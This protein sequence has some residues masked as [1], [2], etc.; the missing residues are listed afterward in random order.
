MLSNR[1]R[2]ILGGLRV[3]DDTLIDDDGTMIAAAIIAGTAAISDSIDRL[4]DSINLIAERNEQNTQKRGEPN[5]RAN[6]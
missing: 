6:E 5:E 3:L 1:F 4:T 2:Q